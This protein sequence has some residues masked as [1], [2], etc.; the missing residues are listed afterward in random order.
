VIFFNLFVLIWCF[1]EASFWWVAPDISICIAYV[2]RPQAWKKFL[3]VGLVGSFL[4]SAVTY[5]WASSSPEGWLHYVAGMP[6]HSAKNIAHVR[7]TLQSD[8]WL[9]IKG[10]WGGIPYKLFFGFAATQ[11]QPFALIALVGLVSRALRFLFSLFVTKMIRKVS[12]PWS[13]RH[14]RQ[15]SAVLMLIWIIMIVV[16][17]VYINRLVV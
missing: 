2:N 7:D 9:V 10:A 17:D 15:L 12:A 16:F 8:P 4:G 5:L 11:G 14:P 13:H 3:V 1:I 6:F